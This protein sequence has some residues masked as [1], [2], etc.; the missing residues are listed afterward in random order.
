MMNVKFEYKGIKDFAPGII[1]ELIKKCYAGFFDYFPRERTRL[2]A[3]WEQE[4][5]AAFENK[6]IGNCMAFTCINDLPVGYFCWDDRQFPVGIVGQ[7]CIL[8]EF[9]GN[10]YGSKQIERIITL[11]QER[12]YRE[13]TVTTG[14]H[15]FF[16][17]TRKMYMNRGFNEYGRI[18]GELFGLIEF[19]KYLH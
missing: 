5:Y 19:R 7:N 10:G 18:E 8:P 2:Y 16:H 6:R 9:R 15:E 17:T 1:Q 13:I 12:N 14:D 3:H 4:D 11:F